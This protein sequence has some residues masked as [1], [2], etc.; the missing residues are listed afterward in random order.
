MYEFDRL[1]KMEK[2]KLNRPRVKWEREVGDT[3]YIP[4]IVQYNALLGLSHRI[5]CSLQRSLAKNVTIIISL[6]FIN[7]LF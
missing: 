3:G 2:Q 7:L 4:P 5:G 1:K 6:F